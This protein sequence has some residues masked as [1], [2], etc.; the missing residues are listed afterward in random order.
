MKVSD[1][2][3]REVRVA[4]IDNTMQSAAQ[5]MADLDAGFLPISD[6]DRLSAW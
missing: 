3:S 6:N 4:A 2:M 1:C 5:I